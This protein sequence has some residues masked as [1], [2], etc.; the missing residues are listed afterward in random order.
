MNERDTSAPDP[1]DPDALAARLD[2]ITNKL[3]SARAELD[4]AVEQRRA[5]LARLAQAREDRRQPDRGTR[6]RGDEGAIGDSPADV[7]PD[8]VDRHLDYLKRDIT[9]AKSELDEIIA[10][11]KDRAARLERFRE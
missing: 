6:H 11:A 4:A 7:L 8:G 1:H 9:E 2:A 3:Q 5:A 10:A